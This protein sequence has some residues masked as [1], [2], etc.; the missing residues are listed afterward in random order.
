MASSFSMVLVLADFSGAK[1]SVALGLFVSGVILPATTLL[2]ILLISNSILGDIFNGYIAMACVTVALGMRLGL[3]I[4]PAKVLGR[5]KVSI[6]WSEWCNLFLHAVGS[7]GTP[8]WQDSC[9]SV[10]IGLQ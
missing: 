9:P 1:I 8:L 2:Y 4:T 3:I 5:V 10:N 6:A 7:V